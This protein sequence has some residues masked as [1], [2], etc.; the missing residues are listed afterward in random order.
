MYGADL[1]TLSSGNV[2]VKIKT[3]T[4]AIYSDHSQSENETVVFNNSNEDELH[5]NEITEH[6]NPDYGD[7]T[8]GTVIYSDTDGQRDSDCVEITSFPNENS[9]LTDWQY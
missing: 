7:I 8:A 4:T 9:Y 5:E 1:Y 3:R 6:L 2:N